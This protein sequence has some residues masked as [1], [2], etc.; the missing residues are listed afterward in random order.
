MYVH[1]LIHNYKILFHISLLIWLGRLKPEL[2]HYVPT[3]M[4]IVSSCNLTET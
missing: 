1:I 3:Y 2:K 4:V